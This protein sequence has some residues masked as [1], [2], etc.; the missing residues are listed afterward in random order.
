L[1][2]IFRI[3]LLFSRI[4]LALA[5]KEKEKDEQS[6]AESSPGGPTMGRSAPAP[7]P[8]PCRL[9]TEVPGI[10]DNLKRVLTLLS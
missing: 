9:C 7:A 8:T 1:F 2:D 3:F 4:D 5:E 10:L 6:W